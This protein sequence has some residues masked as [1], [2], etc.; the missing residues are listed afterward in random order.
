MEQRQTL[1][2][3]LRS[4]IIFLLIIVAGTIGYRMI[5]GWSLLDSLFMTVITLTTVGYNE[6][7]PLSAGGR[8]FSIIL[9]LGGVGGVLYIL[10]ALVPYT[11]S[12]IE[13]EFGLRFGRRRMES[14]IREL[15]GHFILCGYGR[16]GQEIAK[17]FTHEKANFIIIDRDDN[18]ANLAQRAGLLYIKED[19][20]KDEVLKMAG[21][22]RARAL[23]TALGSDADNTYVTLSARTLQPTLP[24]FARADTEGAEEKLRRAGA[25]RVITPYIIGGRRLALLALR[26]VVVEFIETVL[27][28]RD[29]QLLLEEIEVADKSPLA[30]T[31]VKEIEERFPGAR[32]MALRRKDSNPLVNPPPDTVI[33]GED[34][35]TIFGSADHL[36]N[37]ED[38]C[39]V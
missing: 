9:I 18:A 31:S 6:V 20:A 34:R 2:K 38:C 26:P 16:I 14:R 29:Q 39:R 28:N 19:A 5:E 7:H 1:F 8:I 36:H 24:I 10:T 37:L 22:E 11:L 21:I 13:S 30:D 12:I 23:I 17:T 3:L 27:S 32:V 15:S 25:N 35:L 33:K 4:I